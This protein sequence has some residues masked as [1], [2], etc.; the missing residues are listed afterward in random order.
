MSRAILVTGA[1]GFVGRAVVAALAEG[2]RPVVALV[3]RF[4]DDLPAGV[5][6]RRS[7]AIETLDQDGWLSALEG[8]GAVI[9]CAAIAHIGPDVPDSQY[10]AVNHRAVAALADAARI[11]GIDRIVF[12]S[13][14]RAQ[15]GPAS[16]EVQTEA[17]TPQPTDAYGRAKLDGERALSAS[18]VPFVILRPVLVVGDEP[19]GNLRLLARLAR[20]LGRQVRQGRYHQPAMLLTRTGTRLGAQSSASAPL[21]AGRLRTPVSANRP[22][23]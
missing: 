20:D 23:V 5:I 11:A 2:E 9:H 19:K 13:S 18:G 7:P 3:R 6:Q 21:L 12:L 15:C 17:S 8:I 1:T 10:D 4:V 22:G 16:D 14:I